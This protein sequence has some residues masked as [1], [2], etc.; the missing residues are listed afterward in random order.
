MK[1]CDMVSRCDMGIER[2]HPGG[3]ISWGMACT[4]VP[5]N[6]RNEIARAVESTQGIIKQKE[7]IKNREHFSSGSRNKRR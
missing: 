3:H 4:K 1:K 2:G 6:G 7:N 5:Q